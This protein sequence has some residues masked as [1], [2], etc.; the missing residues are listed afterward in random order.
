[1]K[2]LLAISACAMLLL[3]SYI[4]AGDQALL[5]PPGTEVNVFWLSG[6]T[7]VDIGSTGNDTAAARAFTGYTASGDCNQEWWIL[8]VQNHAT[9]SESV[10]ADTISGASP[11]WNWVARKSGCYAAPLAKFTLRS[12][13]DVDM[14]FDGFSD[15]PNQDT[16]IGETISVWYALWSQSAPP[17]PADPAWKSA[18]QLN[19]SD[20]LFQN[21]LSL[22][23]GFSLKLWCKICVSSTSSHAEFNDD[24]I[25]TFHLIKIKIWIDPQTGY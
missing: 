2:G 5:T 7:W 24:A 17:P 4:F 15:L 6:D 20:T 21:S 18:S 22:R 19:N 14:L 13:H 25:I 16:S 10:V 12:N 11:G 8:S 1:M 9:V 3:E 23:Q